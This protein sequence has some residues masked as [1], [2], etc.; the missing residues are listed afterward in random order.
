MGVR[1]CALVSCGVGET[2]DEVDSDITNGHRSLCKSMSRIILAD[3]LRVEIK[4]SN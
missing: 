4:S 3:F 1:M 2:N